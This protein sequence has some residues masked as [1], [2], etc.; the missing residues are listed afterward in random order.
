MFLNISVYLKDILGFDIN[1]TFN[2]DI[3]SAFDN[4]T[5]T[6]QTDI[7]SIP[8]PSSIDGNSL[9]GGTQDMPPLQADADNESRDSKTA[10]RQ[11]LPVPLPHPPPPPAYVCNFFFI[12]FF[13]FYF[14]FFF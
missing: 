8:Q 4:A 9:N 3:G 12:A 1:K 7:I 10:L 14:S 2:S 5:N 6:T 13:I 11:S